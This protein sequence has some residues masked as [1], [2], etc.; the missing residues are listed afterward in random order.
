[1]SSTHKNSPNGD[2]AKLLV[3]KDGYRQFFE[4]VKPLAKIS[5]WV[6]LKSHALQVHLLFSQPKSEFISRRTAWIEERL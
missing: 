1:L 4:F 5:G 6:N 2:I 3:Q